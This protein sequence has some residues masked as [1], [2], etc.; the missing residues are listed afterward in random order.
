MSNTTEL[1]RRSKIASDV[2]ATVSTDDKNHALLL[3][4]KSLNENAENIITA[5]KMDIDA[6]KKK[7]IRAS[8]ID[9]LTLNEDRISAIA[10]AVREIVRLKDPVGNVS[11]GVS[12]PNG[13]SIINTRVPFGV[14]AMIYEARPNVTVDAA[15]LSIKSGNCCILR[16]GSEAINSNKELVRIMREALGESKIPSDAVLLI[17]DTSRESVKEL[18][19]MTDYIDLLIPRGGAGLI[20][21][22]VENAK[23]PVI[24]TGVG[25]CHSYVDESAD[26][27][28]AVKIAV[29]A[30]ASRPS[31]CNAMETLLVHKSLA[32]KYLPMLKLAL[33]EYNV[34]IR[35]CE[36]TRK[37]IPEAV[38]ATEEDYFTEFGDYILAVKVVED[39]NEAISHIKE[40][41]SGHSEAIITDSYQNSSAFIKA[42]D[43]AA[44]YV[45]ASTRFTDGGEFGYGAEIGISTQKMHVRGPMGLS[46]LTTNKFVIRG[47]G[48]IR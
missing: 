30:K 16:G 26:I 42:V 35:G 17:E 33:D 28:M 8:L 5:N 22:V 25:I 15:A 19:C 41:S 29:N 48:Q 23:V 37:I 31:V 44:V 24:E 38:L 40:H 34:E 13:L 10:E 43:A 11:D 46:A 21:T 32:E 6:A 36:I 12:M 3:I 7:G 9:R 20:K 45:N 1:G 39:L 4:A 27:D 47:N 18:L 14:I 2:M